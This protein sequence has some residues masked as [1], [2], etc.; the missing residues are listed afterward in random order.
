MHAGRVTTLPDGAA[1]SLRRMGAES[2]QPSEPAAD[3]ARDD[4]PPWVLLSHERRTSR[5]GGLPDPR[6]LLVQ[7]VVGAV[8]VIVAAGVAGALAGRAFAREDAVND[9][10]RT[11]DILAQA[12]IEPTLSDGLLTADPAALR[13]LDDVVRRSVLSRGIA[14]VKLWT[15]QGRIL[16]ADEPALTGRTAAL[17]DAMRAALAS[18]RVDAV[19]TTMG[20]SDDLV[21]RGTAQ[22]LLE[23]FR[24]VTTPGGH[25]LLFEVHDDLSS[26]QLREQGL[27]RVMVLVLGAAL[28]VVAAL[29]SPLLWRLLHRLSAAAG[30]R[31]RLLHGAINAAQE[32]RRRIAGTL[33]DGPVQDLAGSALLVAQAAEAAARAGHPDIAEPVDAAAATIR[34]NIAGLRLLM[35]D[36]Y[37]PKLTSQN[38]PAVL[39]DLAQPLRSRGTTVVLDVPERVPD[40]ADPDAVLVYRLARECLHNVVKHAGADEVRLAVRT[41][42]P[43]GMVLTIADNGRGF[44]PEQVVG[45]P[46]AGHLGLAI[47]ADLASEA[48]VELAVRARPGAG[49]Q[50]RVTVPPEGL[51]KGYR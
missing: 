12:V 20:P 21:E 19:I 22:D 50:W 30:E 10:M 49:T 9:G 40:L 24:P 16:Y 38:L 39:D 46:A 15:P 2:A 33:H 3:A 35:V 11:I 14:R 43:G 51:R 4:G 45:N 1:G 17:S 7:F 48:G 26:V 37:P 44:E 34:S 47:M 31:E 5:A 29:F 32:E 8:A 27:L 41:P 13:Q 18:G 28:A 25:R 6:T 42:D 36:I 23:V